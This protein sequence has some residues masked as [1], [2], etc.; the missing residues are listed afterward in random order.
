MS[1]IVTRIAVSST[2]PKS[3][4]RAVPNVRMLGDRFMYILISGGMNSFLSLTNEFSFLYA[5]VKNQKISSADKA[6]SQ[7]YR[8]SQSQKPS[9]IANHNNSNRGSDV[10][11]GYSNSPEGKLNLTTQFRF[12]MNQLKQQQ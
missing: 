1:S 12:P 6:K 11:S 5:S 9:Q 10:G 2:F 4:F 3:S 7:S 8:E